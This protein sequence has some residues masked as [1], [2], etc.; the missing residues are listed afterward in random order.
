MTGVQTCALP[1]SNAEESE[2]TRAIKKVLN[3]RNNGGE[4][5]APEMSLPN[6]GCQSGRIL[7]EMEVINPV[8][9]IMDFSEFKEEGF[10]DLGRK[11]K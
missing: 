5:D 10:L 3:F 2:V 4:I 8:K 1:I 7:K 11:I 6:M 9:P